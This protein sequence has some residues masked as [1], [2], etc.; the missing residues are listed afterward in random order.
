MEDYKPGDV[1]TT[2][3]MEVK[4]NDKKVVLI[5][6]ELNESVDEKKD[7]VK[8]YMES[9]ETPAGEKIEIPDQLDNSKAD[10]E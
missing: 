8:E 5:L 2:V 9:Q 1:I 6:D 4:S 3:V 7:A 10:S